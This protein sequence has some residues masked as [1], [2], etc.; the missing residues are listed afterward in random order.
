MKKSC[1]KV[2]AEKNR[3]TKMLEI[4]P[5][6]FTHSLQ[7]VCDVKSFVSKALLLSDSVAL[8]IITYYL[9]LFTPTIY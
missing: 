6:N 7:L 4:R 1:F 9:G 3:E 8:I 2:E 5:F